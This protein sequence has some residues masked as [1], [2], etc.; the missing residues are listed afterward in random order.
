MSATRLLLARHRWLCALLCVAALAL[1]LVVPA[2]FMPVVANGVVV[3]QLCSGQGPQTMTL[4]LSGDLSGGHDAM[5]PDA[6][7]DDPGEEHGKADA[8]CAFAGLSAP[9]LAA[10]DAVL[11]AVAIA[12]ILAG[13]FPPPP[14]RAIRR[15]LYLQPPAIGPPAA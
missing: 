4:D 11:L 10:V 2:G 15:G 3:V 13:A 12:L 8:P 14:R 6:H 9:T 1:R 7:H 5:A